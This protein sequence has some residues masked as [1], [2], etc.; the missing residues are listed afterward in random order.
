M[1]AKGIV[2]IVCIFA[3]W[4]KQAASLYRPNAKNAYH[5]RLESFES[6]ARRAFREVSTLIEKINEAEEI[7]RFA[8]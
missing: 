2:V 5:A 7:N 1:R 6:E 8:S 4:P 3:V